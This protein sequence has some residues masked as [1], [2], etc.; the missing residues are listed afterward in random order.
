MAVMFLASVLFYI[1]RIINT[2]FV[3]PISN[4]MD[5]SIVNAFVAIIFAFWA[6]V[7]SFG[8][9][10][11]MNHVSSERLKH[12]A[13]SD[14]LT[15]LYNRRALSD[16]IF[17]NSIIK[18]NSQFKGA[19][20][21]CDLDNFKLM[22]DNYGHQFGDHILKEVAHKLSSFTRIDDF[23]C[24]YGGDEFFIFL[25]VPDTNVA[26]AVCQKLKSEIEQTIFNYKESSISIT[27]SFGI[28]VSEENDANCS[29]CIR[30][31]DEALYQSKEHGKNRIEVFTNS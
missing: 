15:N 24:R 31:A 23:V 20:V 1:V 19:Y 18:K 30:K 4:F 8:I 12:S 22:N 13:Y 3:S 10:L 29:E 17:N 14:S 11:V 25:Q 21:L 6:G 27:M 28:Y 7:L 2:I 9:F 16:K 5:S 26:L